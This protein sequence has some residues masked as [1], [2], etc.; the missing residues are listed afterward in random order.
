M[1][2]TE[3]KEKESNQR[4]QLP[5]DQPQIVWSNTMDLIGVYSTTDHT[6]EVHRVGYKH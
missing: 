2:Q 3:E 1:N 5:Y 6:I 4:F